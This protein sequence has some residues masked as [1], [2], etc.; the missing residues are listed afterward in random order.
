MNKKLGILIIVLFLAFIAF[1][2]FPSEPSAPTPSPIT[3][4]V[5]FD[6]SFSDQGIALTP[7]ELMQDSR[8]PEGVQ[9][10][11]AGTVKVRVKLESEGNMQEAELELAKP[12]TFVGQRVTLTGVTPA[13]AENR[14]IPKGDYRFQFLIGQ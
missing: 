6:Q 9:C 12:I 11:W 1:K 2:L 8:C 3:G 13:S 7:L 5:G 4:P 10:F 14:I